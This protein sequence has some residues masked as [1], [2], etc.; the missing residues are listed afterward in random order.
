MS[1]FGWGNFWK[2]KQSSQAI[3]KISTTFFTSKI[4]KKYQFKP[5]DA[6]LDFGCGPGFLEEA[7]AVKNIP[8]TGLDINE[9]FIE[10]CRKKYP[11][12]S[13]IH[14]TT[15]TTVNKKILN[16]QLKGKKFDFIIFLSVAQYLNS[17]DEMEDIIKMLL[18]HM[19]EN[20]KLIVGDT[21]DENTSSVRD[22]FALLF[23]CFK[24]AKIATFVRFV[25]FM[26]FSNYKN[27]SKEAQM[28]QVPEVS[29]RKMAETN[30]LNYQRI[31]GLSIHPSRSSYVLS[32][33]PA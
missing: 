28:L 3:T 11:A 15:D 5:G 19:K 14:I 13:F 24:N 20:G 31:N 1:A 10:E 25:S 6:I 29:I 21:L 22:G 26:L 17:V 12:S 23:H 9:F 33:K 32:K 2:Q 27:I 30:S 16:E 8:V 7:L 4:E 18:L